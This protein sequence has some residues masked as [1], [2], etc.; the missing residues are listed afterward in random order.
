[1][2]LMISTTP[3]ITL[4][5]DFGERDGYV[6]TMKGVILGIVPQA[7][8][9]DIS[10]QVDPQDVRQAASILAE[11]YHYF[12]AHTV[13][14]VVVDPGVGSERRPIVLKTPGGIFVAPDNGILTLVRRRE[15][16]AAA[17][18]LDNPDYWLPDP[19]R[20][21]HGRDI[22]SPVAAHLANGVQ[23]N[24][25]GTPVGDLVD[26]S[27][28]EPVVSPGSIWGEVFRI[29][30]FGNILTNITGLRWID[31]QTAACFPAGLGSDP[32]GPVYFDAPSARITIGRNT[33][34]G[35]SQTYSQ[36]SIGQVLSLIGSSGELEISINQGNAQQELGVEVGDPVTIH[37]KS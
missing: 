1:M 32:G 23:L 37:F 13:H 2:R 35:L 21:F 34:D 20:T 17:Y 3:I 5:T 16:A 24:D 36:V 29:D 26:L 6:G 27:L 15:P 25:L 11:A 19:S 7:R 31:D 9:I 8:L 22:F 18:V 12:P 28:A 4:L 33:V 14:L 30:H 10:H